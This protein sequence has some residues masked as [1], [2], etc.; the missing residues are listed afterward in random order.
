VYLGS[1]AEVVRAP[2]LAVTVACFAHRNNAKQHVAIIQYGSRVGP[3][4]LTG[5][6]WFAGLGFFRALTRACEG[7]R[8]DNTVVE[9]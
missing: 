6:G 8:P 4:N 1:V 2:I 5:V 7:L 3:D 9:S